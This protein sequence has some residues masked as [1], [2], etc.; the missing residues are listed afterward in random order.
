[1]T[2]FGTQVLHH[3]YI[4]KTTS[5]F[6]SVGW[7]YG[8]VSVPRPLRAGLAWALVFGGLLT[9]IALSQKKVNDYSDPVIAVSSR[10]TMW[11]KNPL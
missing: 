3:Q 1:M 9:K 6:E 11:K 7:S 10:K 2:T 8:T 4:K 5:S